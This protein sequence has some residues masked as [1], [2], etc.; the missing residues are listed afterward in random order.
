MIRT[1]LLTLLLVFPPLTAGAQNI[2]NLVVPETVPEYSIAKVTVESQA[3]FVFVEVNRT[4]K[5]DF[6]FA[7]LIDTVETIRTL[8][9]QPDTRGYAFTGAP[10]RYRVKVNSFDPETGIDSRSA[11]VVIE[12]EEPPVGGDPD[13][14]S[15]DYAAIKKLAQALVE[16]LDDV[17]TQLGLG[18]AY[19]EAATSKAESIEAINA[20]LLVAVGDVLQ[21]RKGKSLDVN[22][23]GLFAEPIKDAVAG[24]GEL[25]ADE[26]RAVLLAISE[27]LG[28]PEV[29]SKSSPVIPDGFTVKMISPKNCRLCP[30]WLTKVWPTV[31]ANGWTLVADVGP[32]LKFIVCGFGQCC[33]HIG[34]MTYSDFTQLVTAMKASQG[35]IH[36]K[37]K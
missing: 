4:F 20:V 12:G 11:I 18:A 3:K 14:P 36:W 21:F 22:W 16:K 19:L 15:N 8:E 6:G 24:L 30:T 1:A 33:E 2:Q 35:T 37:S 27:G 29:K 32:Q 17:D 13:P 25:G 10:G 23:L 9:S 28:R 5:T 7:I 31:R 26:Y 34:Y